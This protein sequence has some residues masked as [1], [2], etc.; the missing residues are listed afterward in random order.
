MSLAQ[1]YRPPWRHE[2]W[3]SFLQKET[4]DRG[5]GFLRKHSSHQL[6]VGTNLAG[7]S[8]ARW[9]NNDPKIEI[10]GTGSREYPIAAPLFL[11]WL[12]RYKK[13]PELLSFRRGLVC[14]KHKF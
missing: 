7:G 13:A 1:G 14:S 3:N 4:E 5:Y 12:L 2:E 8:I 9:K 11:G 10:G 6:S